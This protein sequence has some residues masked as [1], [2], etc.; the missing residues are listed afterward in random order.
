MITVDGGGDRHPG[1]T[2]ADELK[3]CHLSSSVLHGH[4]VWTQ[5]Q[6][7]AAAINLLPYRVIQVTIHDLLRQS[8]RPS[9]PGRVD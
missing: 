8:E 5:A 2:T 1:Q 6:I 3:H 4:T 7:G 9:E